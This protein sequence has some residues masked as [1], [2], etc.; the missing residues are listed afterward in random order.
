VEQ[1]AATAAELA[2]KITRAFD[3]LGLTAESRASLASVRSIVAFAARVER[4]TRMNVY[5]VLD[6]RSGASERLRAER[7]A[8]ERLERQ[9][10][11]LRAL[12]G[13][14][15][16]KLQPADT[17]TA[18]DLARGLER[19]ITRFFSGAYWSLRRLLNARYDFASQVVKPSWTQLL[20]RLDEEHRVAASIAE[21]ARRARA[22]WGAEGSIEEFATTVEELRGSIGRAAEPVRQ[23]HA[24]LLGSE[25][26]DVLLSPLLAAGAELDALD[27]ILESIFADH[28]SQSLDE[29]GSRLG[30]GCG[31]R[32][33][34][35]DRGVAG[36][37]R[38]AKHK[39]TGTA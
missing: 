29:V 18:L 26:P 3:E 14:W 11:E 2:A 4:L 19:S 12:N 25:R 28:R 8:S 35:D 31:G 24:R 23:L 37:P 36:D 16:E 13:G 9:L 33:H 34:R 1:K 10:T 17:A 38:V 27:P 39:R 15:K 22:H 20:S 6:P 21:D 32:D 7:D 5:D 30:I